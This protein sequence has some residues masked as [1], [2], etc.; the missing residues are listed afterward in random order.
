MGAKKVKG[1]VITGTQSYKVPAVKEYK[2][3]Y[4]R[5]YDLVL[6]S[7]KMDKYDILGTSKNILHLNEIRA[8]PTR[9]FSSSYFE[10]AEGISGERFAD[11]VLVGKSSCVPCPIGCIHIGMHRM[12]FNPEHRDYGTVYVPYDFE[13]I[14]AFGSNL[15]VGTT[16]DVLQLIDRADMR[17]LDAMSTGVVLGW[18]TE[19]FNKGLITAKDL[20][21]L[22]PRWGDVEDYLKMIDYITEP[23]NEFYTLAGQG[24]R[25][26]AD[27]YD[28]V[29]FAVHFCGNEAA[30]YHTGPANIAGQMVG[31]RHS[32]LDN[33]GYSIDDKA[34]SK[35]MTPEA[36]GQALAKEDAQRAVL[37]TL[38]ICLFAR[39][40]FTD[41]VVL[42]SLKALGIDKT[43]DD[44][45]QAGQEIVKARMRFKVQEGFDL[46]TIKPPARLL[47]RLSPH[48][49]VEESTVDRIVQAWRKTLGV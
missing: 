28:G 44:L 40:V 47:E 18:A 34:L 15:G 35:S 36:M 10:G 26:L 33:A 5:V 27:R 24:V 49:R 20:H 46:S 19:A 16:T 4:K 32:H 30:G 45:T 29:D 11:E 2:E 48:G 22:S 31:L 14:Y 23:P 12:Q 17:G 3:A 43:I 42:G 37:N 7:G 39:P 41:D 1:I 38:I 8:L 9:N 6:K 13:L 21:G 25:V